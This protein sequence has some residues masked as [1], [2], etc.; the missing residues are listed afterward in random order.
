VDEMIVFHALSKEHLKEIVEIQ[1][2]NL[3]HRL[4]DRNIQIEVTP[5]GREFLVRVGYDP[6]YGARPLKRSIQKELE[7]PLGRLIL[8][9]TVKDGGGVLVDYDTSEDGLTFTPQAAAAEKEVVAAL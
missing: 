8:Q 7:N 1:L 3:V 2:Q 9:G 4:A 5:E 6:N